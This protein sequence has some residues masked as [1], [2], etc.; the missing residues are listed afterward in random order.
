MEYISTT[1]IQ[2]ISYATTTGARRS[3]TFAK[4]L[5]IMQ[6]AAKKQADMYQF[7]MGFKPEKNENCQTETM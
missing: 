5:Q 4:H 3:S 1:Q 6:N 2:N 7:F